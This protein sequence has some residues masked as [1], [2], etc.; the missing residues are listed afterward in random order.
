METIIKVKNLSKSFGNVKAVNDISFEVQKGELFGFLGVNGAGKSTTI[1]M[2]CTLA[3]KTSGNVQVCGMELGKKDKEI[4]N[5]IGVVFQENSLDGLLTVKQNLISRAYLYE[6]NTK[7]IKK[8][9]DNVC[10]ILKIGD[11][12]NRPFKELSGGQK[13]SCD[14]A[15]ALMNTPEILFLD[16]PTTGLDPKTRQNLWNSIE[17]LRK[18]MKMTVFLTTHYMEEAAKAQHIS[19]MDAGRIVASGTPFKLKE[20]YS[21]DKLKV[22]PANKETVK[23]ILKSNSIKYKEDTNRLNIEIPNSLFAIS[24]LEKLQQHINSFEVV[25]GTMEDAFLN[26]TGKSLREA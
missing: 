7:K 5:K 12:L 14:I 23:S 26:I 4:R 18:E 3:Q 20:E 16:E 21:M 10:E 25:Q 8:N 24:L 15:R 22:E 1:N 9:L 6:S 19:V 2:I 13:R 11:L 17:Y